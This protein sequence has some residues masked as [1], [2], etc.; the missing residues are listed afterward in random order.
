MRVS[1]VLMLSKLGI[2][3]SVTASFSYAITVLITLL[4]TLEAIEQFQK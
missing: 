3:E 2:S 1:I 4:I